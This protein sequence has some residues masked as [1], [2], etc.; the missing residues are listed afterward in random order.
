MRNGKRSRKQF[1]NKKLDWLDARYLLYEKKPNSL[2]NVEGVMLSIEDINRLE[3]ENKRLKDF[4][5]W[6]LKQQYYIIHKNLK[7]K[8]KEVLSE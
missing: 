1:T 5:K 3:E 8:I 2:Q 7:A 4:L 6:L